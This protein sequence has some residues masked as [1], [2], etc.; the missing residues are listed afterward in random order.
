MKEHSP[1]LCFD[2]RYIT[3]KSGL[4]DSPSSAYIYVEQ[5]IKELQIRGL[6]NYKGESQLFVVPVH[7]CVGGHAQ[8]APLWHLQMGQGV[9]AL[10][11]CGLIK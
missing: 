8:Y 6:W 1:G 11:M 10:R 4:R 3:A 9:P 2:V 5:F 7:V